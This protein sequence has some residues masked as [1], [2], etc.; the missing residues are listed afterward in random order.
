MYSVDA[1]QLHQP[2]AMQN[3]ML[4]INPNHRAQGAPC[5]AWTPRS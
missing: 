2:H 3:P 1:V 5:T 4:N